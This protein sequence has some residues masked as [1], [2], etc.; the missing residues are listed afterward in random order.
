MRSRSLRAMVDWSTFDD[1]DRQAPGLVAGVASAGMVSA[2]AA[3]GSTEQAGEALG[4]ESLL[5]VASIAKQ[6]TAAAIA[7]LVLDG[8]VALEDSVRRW[9]PELKPGWEEVRVH[10]LVSH[11]G[12]LREGNALDVAAGWSVNSHIST[13][14]RV[15]IIARTEPE[16]PPGTVHRYSNHGYVLLAAVVEQ[17]TGTTLGAFARLTLFE[18]VGMT[19]PRFLDEAGPAAGSGWVGGSRRV[20]IRF[21]CTGD[22]G[23]VTTLDDLA[24]WDGWLPRSHLAGLMLA[25]RQILPNGKSAHDAWGISVRRHHGLRIESHGGSID[26]Y[27]ASFVRFPDPGLSIIVMANTDQLGIDDFG[28]R[29]RELA[30]TLL[31]EQLDVTLPPWTETHGIPVV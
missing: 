21:T 16:S 11:T 5:Y 12:G 28:R 15:A 13:S 19:N 9:L 7:S 23:L 3:F 2:W 14:D 25:A 29:A 10:H 4:R 6:F 24:R 18:P 27:M 26:G 22:G 30:N 20:D 8:R 31:G 1:L 17:A